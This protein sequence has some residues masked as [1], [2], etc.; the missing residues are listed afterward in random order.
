MV[1]VR[2]SQIPEESGKPY[3]P[4]KKRSKGKP[5]FEPFYDDEEDLDD[6]EDEEKVEPEFK[7]LRTIVNF[8]DVGISMSLFG[9]ESIE[10]DMR[11]LDK[12]KAHWEFGIVINKGVPQSMRFPKVDVEVWFNTEE[13]RDKRWDSI[14][15]TLKSEGVKV[16]GL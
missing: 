14:I 4:N 15:E 16:I 5:L 13:V 8:E 3:Y 12:P 11:F 7:Y 6:E 10:K 1:K 9:I 2:V